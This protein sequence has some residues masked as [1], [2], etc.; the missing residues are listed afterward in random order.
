MNEQPRTFAIGDI[1]GC[2]QALATL[3]DAISLT[4][5]DTIITLG[6]YI[7]RGLDSKGVLDRLIE[8]SQQCHLIP[9]LGNHE[10]MLLG[11]RE[12]RSDFEFFMQCGGISTLDS[13][14]DTGR[15]S[16]I[17]REHWQFIE[18][19]RPYHETDKHIFVHA[20][21]APNLPLDQHD[22]QTLHWRS[23]D[24]DP[25][26]PHYSGKTVFVGHTPQLDGW[27]LDMGHL[28]CI[29]T[30]CGCG[31][32]L[33]AIDVHRGKIWQSDEAGRLR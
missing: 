29:D 27:V 23:L 1:H 12:G 28:I 31:G 26:G 15:L 13:Y 22:S 18:S 19:C 17:P 7:N 4:P 10:E 20:N 9:L 5:K 25:P 33:T 32:W 16:L 2:S 14:G 3:I 8:L 24:D 11:A 6:D 21:Y 30:G